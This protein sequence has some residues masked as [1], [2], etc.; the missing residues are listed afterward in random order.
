MGK[1]AGAQSDI[2]KK[3]QSDKSYG[4]KLWF[5]MYF[6]YP[7]DV[8]VDYMCQFIYRRNFQRINSNCFVS[9]CLRTRQVKREMRAVA[10]I[11]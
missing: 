5:A 2:S 6:K 10:N 9:K 8:W 3:L 7:R 1:I 11:Y 4:C